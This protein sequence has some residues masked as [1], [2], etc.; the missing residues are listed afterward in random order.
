MAGA[1][2]IVVISFPGS[3][4]DRDIMVAAAMVSGY[5]PRLVW[6]KE[7]DIGKPDLV[8]IPGGFSFGDYLRCGAIAARSAAMEAV[9][10]HAFR[11]GAVLGICN[12]FQVL[13]EAG[14]LPGALIRNRQLRFVCRKV[15]LEVRTQRKSLLSGLQQGSR[16]SLPVAHNEGNFF[17]DP[18][19]LAKLQD[20]DRIAL[21]YTPLADET[22][23]NPNG[24]ELDIAGII[25][26]NG[27]VF[28]L[29]PHPERMMEAAHG[30]TD[31]RQLLLS[32]VEACQ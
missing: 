18:D 28:G 24:A 32:V 25:S 17:A 7:S 13:T 1:M 23:Y 19:T 20:D 26:E 29:M 12:G 9:V 16:L 6:H 27:R 21:T 30:G 15:G 10:E 22:D 5:Q 11:G 4:C 31:G 8:I 3:N 14:L 2:E